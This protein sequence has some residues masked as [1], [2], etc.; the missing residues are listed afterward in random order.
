MP[1]TFAISSWTRTILV[2]TAALCLA[3][4]TCACRRSSGKN[5]N[6][7]GPSSI[8]ESDAEQSKREAKSLV[9]KG[10]ELS[11]PD[12]NQDEQAVQAFQ[13]AIRLQPD[14]AEAHLRLGMAYAALDKKTEAETSYKK[15]IELYKRAIQADSKDAD[16]FFNLGQAH[17]FLHQDEEAARSYRQATRLRPD[18]EEAFY[19]L[20]R[21]E[22]KLAHYPE[23]TAAFQKALDL[24]PDDSRAVEALDNA[25]EG[26]NRIKEG[27]KHAEDMLKKQ[28]ENANANGNT[29]SNSRSR[30]SP[31]PG[32][33]RF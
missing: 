31:K 17:S 32:I 13:E 5:A 4:M 28:Q 30:P 33:R 18:D 19:Q 22:T 26:A 6:A 12:H 24:N 11:D 2:V 8:T 9:D 15:A 16:A 1:T 10:K 20:G 27:K 23:A 25:R 7:N 14:L 3:A 29:N 21:A